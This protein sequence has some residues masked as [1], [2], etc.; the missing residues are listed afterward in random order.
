MNK[1]KTAQ[2]FH[3]V[4]G[5]HRRAAYKGMGFTDD[6]MKKPLVAVVNTPSEVC[7]GHFHLRAVADAVKAGVWQAG[8]T[9]MEF[10]SISQCAT[11]SLGL[12]SMRY[13]LPA[14]GLACLRYRDHRG[15]P[16]LRRGRR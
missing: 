15:D 8:G 2:Y 1:L 12:A 7:P 4:E 9:P 10:T 13:D 16:D 3:G 14:Q 6:D 5:T 11:P